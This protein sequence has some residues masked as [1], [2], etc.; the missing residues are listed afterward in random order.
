MIFSS[1][2]F[3]RTFLVSMKY[4]SIKTLQLNHCSIILK[5]TAIFLNHGLRNLNS[6]IALSELPLQ[7]ILFTQPERNWTFHWTQIVVIL[8]LFTRLFEQR[9]IA[10]YSKSNSIN[11]RVQSVGLISLSS[12]WV[13][14][15][16]EIHQ[17]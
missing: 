17:I 16:N 15:H 8:H 7:K 13:I 12:K 14:L 10:I 2:F 11:N 3:S 4:G 5:E 1:Y 6:S 9:F